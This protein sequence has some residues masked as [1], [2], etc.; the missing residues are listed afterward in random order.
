ML[1]VRKLRNGEMEHLQQVLQNP[2]RDLPR[3][4]ALMIILSHEGKTVPEIGQDTRICLHPIHIRK[5]IHRFNEDGV[6]GLKSKKSPGRPRAFN[7]KT[8]NKI[9]KIWASPPSTLQCNF[10]RWSLQRLVDYLIINGHVDSISVETARGIVL[11]T[12]KGQG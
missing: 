6:E 8:R 5:W 1:Y 7:E 3:E 9:R 2:L 4:R 11:N 12:Q 10:H